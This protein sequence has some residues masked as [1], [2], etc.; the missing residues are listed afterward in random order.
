MYSVGDKFKIEEDGEILTGEIINIF[1]TCYKVK[2]SDSK[3]T[4]EKIIDP[5]RKWINKIKGETK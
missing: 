1:I 3:I 4:Y 5:S 2:W